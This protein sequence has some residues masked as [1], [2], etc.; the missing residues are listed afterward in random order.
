MKKNTF[1]LMLL[2]L[3]LCFQVYSQKP[4]YTL[5]IQAGANAP[6]AGLKA[7]RFFLLNDH[8]HISVALGIGWGKNI[9][10]MNDLTY[11]YGDGRNFL[12]VGIMGVYSNDDYVDKQTLKYIFMPLIGYRYISPRMGIFGIHFTPVLADNRVY[13]WG[14]ISMGIQ[15][16]RKY[17]EGKMNIGSVRF[18]T[19]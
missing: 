12:E 5:Q 6:I 7:H 10:L 8:S 14:G 1:S 13:F 16:K 2:I 15:L 9:T 19:K 4:L 11:A 17:K 3:L 18:T